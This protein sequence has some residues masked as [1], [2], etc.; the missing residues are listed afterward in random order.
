[1]YSSLLG[2]CPESLVLDNDVL[3]AI[4]RAVRGIEVNGGTLGFE[5]LSE[6]CLGNKG[7]YLGSKLTLSVMQSEYVYPEVGN[8]L[9]P[10][11]WE[12]SSKP[13]A[14]DNALRTRDQILSSYV[15]THISPEIHAEIKAKFPIKLTTYH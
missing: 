9:S 5:D 15:P 13:S 1:M 6:V 4:L 3:G 10:V 12:Q 2:A 8:R 11:V 14:I 7:H